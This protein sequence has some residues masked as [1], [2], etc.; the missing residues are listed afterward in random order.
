MHAYSADL[1][2]LKSLH[3]HTQSPRLGLVDLDTGEI[4]EI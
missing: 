2:A 1:G 3:R 4:K